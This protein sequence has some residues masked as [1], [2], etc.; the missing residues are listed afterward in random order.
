MSLESP[1]HTGRLAIFSPQKTGWERI[2]DC[3]NVKCQ[4]EEAEAYSEVERES[5]EVIQ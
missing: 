5:R 4:G 3:L 1:G 2:P